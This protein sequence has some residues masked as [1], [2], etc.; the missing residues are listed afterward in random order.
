MDGFMSLCFVDVAA[1]VTTTAESPVNILHIQV[2]MVD[3]DRGGGGG[4]WCIQGDGQQV[5][6]EVATV[7]TRLRHLDD[8]GNREDFHRQVRRRHRRRFLPE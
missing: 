5:Q 6:E 7:A 8:I 4:M 1:Y 3:D 2:D